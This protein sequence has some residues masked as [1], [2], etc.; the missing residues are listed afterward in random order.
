MSGLLTV[1]LQAPWP[2]YPRVGTRAPKKHSPSRFHPR[3]RRSLTCPYNCPRAEE[4][5]WRIDEQ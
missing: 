5:W 3:S 2:L 1:V 4:G